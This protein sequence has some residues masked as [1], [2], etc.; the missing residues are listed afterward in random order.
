MI[1]RIEFDQQLNELKTLLQDMGKHMEE[2][3]A[4]S[5]ES[6]QT[7]DAEKAQAVIKNDVQLNTMEEQ[8]MEIG[9]RLIVTQQPV[10]KDL[11]RILVAFRI[12]S[13][14]ERMGDLARDVAKVTIRL[15]GQK[16]IKPLVDLPRMSDLV[17]AMVSESI[18]SYLME[19][20]DLAYKMAQDDDQVDHLYSVI[21]QDL[22]SHLTSDPDSANQAM[23]LIMVG[24]YIERIADH[25]T[26][27]GESTVY[28]VTGH[29]PDLNQ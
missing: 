23:L 26:N 25:A 24:R 17:R 28:L 22:Y 20:T 12:A 7:L 8:I 3:L 4:S 9:S 15:Q 14:L 19:N 16:L 27:I 1:R 21:L 2:A 29:R 5:V 6:L 18:E 11:R 13:D 10:A